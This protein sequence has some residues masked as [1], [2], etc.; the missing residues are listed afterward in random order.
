MRR[1]ET[2]SFDSKK[3]FEPSSLIRSS[4]NMKPTKLA[5]AWW[6]QRKHYHF[7]DMPSWLLI[8]LGVPSF[9]VAGYWGLALTEV[10]PLYVKAVN[11]IG[12]LDTMGTILGL[13][14]LI[15]GFQLW[16]FGAVATRC[17]SLL[18]ERWFK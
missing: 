1:C 15:L 18:Y 2:D 13:I 4:G 3:Q 16:F 12:Y 7:F 10:V 17:H 8:A 9:L 14:L 5:I 11:K 6:H